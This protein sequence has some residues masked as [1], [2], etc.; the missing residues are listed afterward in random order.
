MNLA[1]A[2][3][4]SSRGA[5]DEQS[6]NLNWVCLPAVVLNRFGFS[7]TTSLPTPEFL[8]D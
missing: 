3:T 4:V 1:L 8:D 7:P 5:Y 2:L 6:A